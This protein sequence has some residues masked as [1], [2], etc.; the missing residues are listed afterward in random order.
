MYTDVS[1]E[2]ISSKIKVYFSDTKE[3]DDRWTL[4]YEGPLYRSLNVTAPVK[5]PESASSVGNTIYLH[6]QII[7]EEANCPYAHYYCD[8]KNM[9]QENA[10]NIVRDHSRY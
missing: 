6:I 1:Q 10:A 3:Q 8:V 7:D 9:N 4:I 2:M 5:K